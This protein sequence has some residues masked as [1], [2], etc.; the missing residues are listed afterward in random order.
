MTVRKSDAAVSLITD[1]DVAGVIHTADR[2]NTGID[3]YM[4]IGGAP[5]AVLAPASLRCSRGQ[6]QARLVLD[7]VE[8]RARAADMGVVDPAR[9]TRSKTWSAATACLRYP[10]S[11]SQVLRVR[12]LM[13]P[14]DDQ[15]LA[16]AR[17]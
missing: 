16:E 14:A 9:N 17:S 1:G 8:A 13:T 3:I 10:G 15:S 7:E 12:Q 2:D 4:G 11:V 6:M 5:E